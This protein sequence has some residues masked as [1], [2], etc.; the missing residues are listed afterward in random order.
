MK[1]DRKFDLTISSEVMG[2]E[3]S[4]QN[5]EFFEDTKEGR[6]PL[7]FYSTDIAAAWEV[8]EKLGISL[9][10]IKDGGWFAIAG[11]S[12]GWKSPADFLKYLQNADFAS[13]GAAVSESAPMAI[14][15]A[16]VKAAQNRKLKGKRTGDSSAPIT[17]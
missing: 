11:A 13:S 4:Q 16:A 6:K 14:C 3:V 7:R 8:A 15:I 9:I 10:A 1:T 12:R 17:H 2:Y 5:N